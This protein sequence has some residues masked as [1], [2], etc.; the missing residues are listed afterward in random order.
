MIRTSPPAADPVAAR[1]ASQQ[2]PAGDPEPALDLLLN[3]R[4]SEKER[5]WL[6]SLGLS[7]AFHLVLLVPILYW[8]SLT[9]QPPE[10]ER[11]VVHTITPL[12]MPP[13]LLTQKAP[14]RNKVS[15]Q[16]DLAD[17]L[18]RQQAS[19][20]VVAPPPGSV[21]KLEVPKNKP[22]THARQTA[23][24]IKEQPPAIQASE[25]PPQLPAG[26]TD[27]VL[28]PAPPRQEARNTMP[29]IGSAAPSQRKLAPPKNSLQDVIRS[30]A[31]DS[32]TTR[33]QISDDGPNTRLP[34]LPGLL[35]ATGQMHSAIEL[36]SDPQGADFR[37]YLAQIL[38]IVRRHWFSVLPESARMGVLRGRTTIQFMINRN[39]SIPKLVIADPSG[40]EPLD[41]AAV[42]GLSMSNPLP[43]L[44]ADFKGEFI[45]L[46]FSF[47]Y[48]MP[49]E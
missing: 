39:G 47:N 19:R 5:Q 7:L 29:T 26:A 15:K 41:R 46:Q 6:R 12:Y 16:F 14:N 45:R 28:A 40:R 18:A 32:N 48:N 38:A 8:G 23:P 34:S 49:S 10:P 35:P 2:T 25:T 24:E 30:M 27:S 9:A 44:P 33:L 42:A 21:R 43:P 4:S 20:R 37:P 3:W 31:K 1:A 36:Q 22:D 17:L 11:E 13:D